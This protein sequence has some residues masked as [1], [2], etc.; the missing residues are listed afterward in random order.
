MQQR[1]I[2]Y[3]VN[4]VS[5]TKGSKSSLLDVIVK[6]TE[7]H[8]IA[9]EIV[10]TNARGD[11][12]FLKEKISKEK[13]TDIVICGGDG[14]VSA[15]AAVLMGIEVNV[16]IIPMGSGNGL[17]LCAGIPK[18]IGKALE[19]IFKGTASYVDGFYINDKFSCML[20]G[21]GLDAKVAHDF[22]GRKKRGLKTYI[23]LSVRNF[24][25]ALP[26][27]FEIITKE[28][29]FATEAFFISIANSNQFGNNFTIAPK[30]S[31]RDGLLD[32]VIVK[33]MNK[34]FMLFAVLNHITRGNNRNDLVF[35]KN[36]T[37]SN[38]IYF[39]TPSL[40]IVNPQHAPLHID[41]DPKETA[42]RF[43][44]RVVPHAFKLI[45]P[46]SRF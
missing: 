45:Q 21:I 40:S 9:F 5:G 27:R 6:A 41:G 39:Q 2:I 17:A 38:V 12:E 8:A 25:K 23:S 13:I 11:Y 15:V 24:F 26:F 10:Y 22:A 20:S 35:K 18:H 30:A 3:L 36:D 37:S 4:P 16:G 46:E 1:K 19:L 7:K 28:R 32:V 42:G 29:S 44:I 34:L 31:L 14:S 33:R 43:E